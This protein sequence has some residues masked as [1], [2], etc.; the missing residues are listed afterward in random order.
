[1]GHSVLSYNVKET[2]VLAQIRL[3]AVVHSQTH[4]GKGLIRSTLDESRA[5]T[6]RNIFEKQTWSNLLHFTD[7]SEAQGAS[8][9]S[10]V[11]CAVIHGTQHFPC[12]IFYSLFYED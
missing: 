11:A 6:L 3:T 5:E 7:E 12:F 10:Q 1:M 2:E 9:V 8:S 4:L